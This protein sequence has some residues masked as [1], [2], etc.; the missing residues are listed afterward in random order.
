MVTVLAVDVDRVLQEGRDVFVVGVHS[1]F[2]E[3]R[4]F[5]LKRYN[6][7]RCTKGEGENERQAYLAL[8]VFIRTKVG[9]AD[10]GC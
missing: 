1:L 9:S 4:A 5:T 3:T 7:R 2:G 10:G 8:F 6:V